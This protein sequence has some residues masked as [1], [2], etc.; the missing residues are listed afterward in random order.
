MLAKTISL[1][2]SLVSR[3]PN[4]ITPLDRLF[5]DVLSSWDFFPS[6]VQDRTRVPQHTIEERD[7]T[8]HCEVDLPGVEEKDIK[9]TVE[10]GYIMIA[11]SRKG[12]E[13]KYRFSHGNAYDVDKAEARLANGVLTLVIPSMEKPQPKEIKLL[14]G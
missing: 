12:A 5:D 8:L 4:G 7:G 10:D 9:I 2:P 1:V 11:G 6:T 3:R 13:F 14:S